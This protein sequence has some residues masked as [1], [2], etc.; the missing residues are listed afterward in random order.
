M[1]L[2][3][4]G[5][6]Y[7]ADLSADP[8]NCGSC[9]NSCGGGEFC[10][11]GE[12]KLNC[13]VDQTTC[14]DGDGNLYCADD[15]L[16]DRDNCGGCGIECAADEDCNSGQCET[17]MPELVELSS[18]SDLSVSTPSEVDASCYAGPDTF[19]SGSCDVVLCGQIETWPFSYSDNRGAVAVTRVDRGNEELISVDERSGT[20]YIWDTTVDVDD[21]T[22]TFFGQNEGTVTIPWTQVRL[23]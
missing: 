10:D 17:C 19:T 9:E 8:N 14:S 15:L 3:D 23:P 18:F 2:C 4:N 7:C 22:V 12:C 1:T 16:T 5:A 21:E 13:E 20:R 11:G 6:G